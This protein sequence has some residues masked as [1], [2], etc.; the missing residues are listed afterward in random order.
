[1][2]SEAPSRRISLGSLDGGSVLPDVWAMTGPKSS[3]WQSLDV[4]SLQKCH[5]ESKYP[6]IPLSLAWYDGNPVNGRGACLFVGLI[7]APTLLRV[8]MPTGPKPDPKPG[9][10]NVL[11][12]DS[13]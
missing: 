10:F 9:R 8:T 4:G 5:R 6:N 12:L 11:P 2:P 3:T 7:Y 1:M 13:H